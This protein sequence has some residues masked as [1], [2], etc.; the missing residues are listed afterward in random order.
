MAAQ[1]FSAQNRLQGT[2]VDIKGGGSP[3]DGSI[4]VCIALCSGVPGHTGA[5]DAAGGADPAAGTFAANTLARPTMPKQ[6]LQ[7][8]AELTTEEAQLIGLKPGQNVV[9]V[10]GASPVMVVTDS[11]PLPSRNRLPGT[12]RYVE[13]GLSNAH[14]RI[15]LDT[16]AV[17]MAQVTTGSLGRLRIVPGKKVEALINPADV[18]LAVTD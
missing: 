3:D 16:G 6:G 12:V 8:L 17:L 7:L 14:V 11:C 18:L 4:L 1:R 15:Q 2:V 13:R 10:F 9:A 5:C